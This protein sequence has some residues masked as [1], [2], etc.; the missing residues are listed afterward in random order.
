M[1]KNFY[2]AL[3]S[4]LADIRGLSLFSC[5]SAPLLRDFR[6]L[7][8][9]FLELSGD[10][11]QKPETLLKGVERWGAF[12]RTLAETGESFS[13]GIASMT[14]FDDNP[15]TRSAED[16]D[17]S[18]IPA[19]LVA[20]AESDLRR[21]KRIA[22]FDLPKLGLYLAE[23]LRDAELSG[24]AT[25]AAEEVRA[26]KSAGNCSCSSPKDF[27][28]LENFSLDKQEKI[29]EKKEEK[30]R[31]LAAYL[32]VHGAGELGRHSVFRWVN[33]EIKP[34]RNPDGVRLADLAG[35]A[36]QR[37]LI[38]AN[39]LR[40]A[41][42]KPANNLFL[43]GDRGTGKSATVKAVCAE[44]SDRGLKLLEL[45]KRDAVHL[46]RILEE[47]SE[48]SLRFI[49]FIDDLSFE[50]AD[51]SFTALKMALE[52]G[53]SAKPANAAVYITSNRRH[54]VKERVADR[55]N[56]GASADGD[57]RTF[58]SMQEQFSLADRFG[59]T[60]L[61]TAPNQEEFLSIAEYVAVRRGLFRDPS[62]QA[63]RTRFRENALKWE[64]WFNGRSPRTAVQYADWVAG[65][66]GF[67]WE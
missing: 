28:S 35:Y 37:S 22:G 40:F 3:V 21:L 12:L 14:V 64:R 39:T 9:A 30:L 55:P 18:Q 26:L 23:R 46:P 19:F 34:V 57:M 56:A 32:R 52:G 16:R 4:A 65:G 25:E 49:I 43:Y 17:F 45:A 24:P 5:G 33:G 59:L 42:G 10:T 2:A 29:S 31:A 67:P 60:V 62:N 66:S 54:L 11:G 51:D 63:E 58:D 8:E 50:T 44:Y 48:R 47:L 61:F 13:E 27:F 38:A 1:E 6:L 15:F 41:E 20:V 36:E 7:A 53:V